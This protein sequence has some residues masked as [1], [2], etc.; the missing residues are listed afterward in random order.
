MTNKIYFIEL[1][2]KAGILKKIPAFLFVE[3]EPF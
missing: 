2:E 1:L 3:K